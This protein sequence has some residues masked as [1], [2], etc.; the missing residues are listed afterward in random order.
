[1]P[2]VQVSAPPPRRTFP[3]FSLD[4]RNGGSAPNAFGGDVSFKIGR[5]AALWRPICVV[6]RPL[7]RAMI[8]NAATPPLLVIERRSARSTGSGL[9]LGVSVQSVAKQPPA[10]FWQ[11]PRARFMGS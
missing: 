10:F 6:D 11:G 4:S 1:M 2:R 9:Q 3:R 5:D 7:R 8:N